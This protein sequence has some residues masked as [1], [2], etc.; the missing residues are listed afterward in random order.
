LGQHRLDDLE[1]QRQ[2]GERGEELRQ[3]G[4]ELLERGGERVEQS[5]ADRHQVEELLAQGEQDA[6][7]RRVLLEPERRRRAP[8]VAVAQDG[9]DALDALAA[10]GGAR[11]RALGPATPPLTDLL[12]EGGGLPGRVVYCRGRAVSPAL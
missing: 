10:L 9:V 7:D 1:Q 11:A 5:L 6:D 8:E 4:A 3:H 12:G 2:G